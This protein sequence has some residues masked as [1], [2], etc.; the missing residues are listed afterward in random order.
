MCLEKEEKRNSG[1]QTLLRKQLRLSGKRGRALFKAKKPKSLLEF[2]DAHAGSGNTH[3]K[4]EQG[5]RESRN[6]ESP[7]GR[8]LWCKTK[9]HELGE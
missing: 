2:G 1:G 7:A 3:S 4:K 8:K 6:H 5:A 9:H